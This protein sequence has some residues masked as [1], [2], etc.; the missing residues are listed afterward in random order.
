M[1]LSVSEFKFDGC[2]NPTLAVDE[3]KHFAK[4]PK[5]H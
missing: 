2:Y 3:F 1:S 5:S 4:T